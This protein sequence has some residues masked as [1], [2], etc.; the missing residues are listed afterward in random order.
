MSEHDLIGDG[1][2]N[3]P[4]V[5][6]VI[7]CY[8]HARYIRECIESAI[9]QDYA[10]IELI[11]IDDGSSDD[12]VRVIEQLLPACRERFIRF[13]FRSRPNKGISA[14]TNEALQWLSGK[15]FAALD[16]DDILM[17]GK[18][19][20]L[21]TVLEAE[22]ELAGVFCG[23]ETIDE[24]GMVFGQQSPEERYFTFDE[25]ILH[26]HTF[27]TPGM[28]L[29][30]ADVRQV[31]GYQNAVGIQ[32]WYMWLKLTEAGNRLKVVPEVLVKYRKHPHNISKNVAKMF[33]GRKQTLAHFSGH[34]RYGLAMAGVNVWAA[35]DYSRV[36]KAKSFSRLLQ[37]IRCSPKILWSKYFAKGL[38]RSLTPIFLWQRCGW[39]E[40]HYPKLYS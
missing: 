3:L 4:L 35:I 38:V 25:I 18:I 28:F 14:T 39:L 10:N 26:K 9:A 5:S 37:A 20:H 1:V 29:K 19:S 8:N 15:Y 11:I 36:S 32:D 17:P 21:L 40:S 6:I 12:S 31:G 33:E 2:S 16:S 30:M 7:P 23:L 13:E 22:P 27:A 34:K 24:Q